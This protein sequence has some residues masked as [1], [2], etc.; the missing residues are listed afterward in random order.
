[1]NLKDKINDIKFYKRRV[2]SAEIS[3]FRFVTIID[4]LLKSL[5]FMTL[6]EVSSADKIKFSNIGF[7]FIF[8]Y[9]AFIL[10]FYSFGYLFSKNK[11]IVYYIILNILFSTLLI[12]DLWYF[13]VNRDFLGLKNIFFSGT[14]NPVGES[15]YQFKTIDLLFVIDIVAIILFVFIKKIRSTESRSFGKFLFTLRHVAIILLMYV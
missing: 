1:M 4:M 3:K 6:V 8:V 2:F 15:L 12:A 9:L 7:K 10:L 14:F 13:R 11:Q 5:I